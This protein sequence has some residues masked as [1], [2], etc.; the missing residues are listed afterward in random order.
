MLKK[1]IL[2]LILAICPSLALAQQAAT[3]PATAPTTTP[4]TEPALH[5]HIRATAADS[6]EVDVTWFDTT[7]GVPYYRLD[8]SSDNG[9]TWQ[10]A[11]GA[12]GT[13]IGKYSFA[14][15]TAAEQTHYQYRVADTRGGILS[16]SVDVTTPEKSIFEAVNGKTTVTFTDVRKVGFWTTSLQLLLE[17]LKGF[18][19]RLI[20]A[21]ILFLIFYGFYRAMRHLAIRSM[22]RAGIDPSIHG[23]LI[24]ILRVS[25]LGF[26][27]IVAFDQ[28][29][30]NIGTLL[31][32]VSIIGLAI[33]FAAQ[34]TLSNMIASIIIFCDK[35]F[36]PGDWV[37]I[38]S[39]S[40]RIARITFRSTRFIDEDGSMIVIPNT[41][42]MGGQLINHSTYPENRVSVPI[43]VPASKPLDRV[44][45]ALLSTTAGDD[46]L[47]KEYTPE[48]VML[49]FTTDS[50]NL[51]LHLW[52]ENESLE[53]FVI[54]DYLERAKKALD[55][56][57]L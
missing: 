16:T 23:M 44:R 33:G 10:I 34:D 52:I 28:M 3:A 45:A 38:G 2:F 21:L 14:D 29:G 11:G 5:V 42:I 9:K 7:G 15:K 27:L 36:K 12:P 31:A 4:A 55:A 17:W 53:T 51:C 54:Q 40:G 26:G 37:T 35:P 25:I 30:L 18:V 32:G 49:S 19:P 6:S 57:G 39:Q 56:A 50:M 43:T 22:E 47:S 8:R 46:R 24:T 41:V 13:G 1:L 48:V 20:V